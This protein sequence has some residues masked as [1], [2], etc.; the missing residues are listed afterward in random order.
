MVCRTAVSGEGVGRI[1][2]SL[3]REGPLGGTLE[4]T[5]GE[6]ADRGSFQVQDN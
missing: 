4:E 5:V 3:V 6:E 2:D 1:A